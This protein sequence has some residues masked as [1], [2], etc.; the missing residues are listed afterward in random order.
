MC[1]IQSRFE[2]NF[3]QKFRQIVKVN[4]KSALY[5]N[6]SLCATLRLCEFTLYK[7]PFCDQNSHL[8]NFHLVRV[9]FYQKL[10][11]ILS[12]CTN[13]DPFT[14]TVY[15]SINFILYEFFKVGTVYYCYVLTLC[16]N[17]LC[18]SNFWNRSLVQ[19]EGLL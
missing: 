4:L 15:S 10:M 2:D 18:T 8:V 17:S 5:S 3:P 19:S 16:T 11:N 13:F 14:G 7:Q 12:F 9:L 1:P 6:P